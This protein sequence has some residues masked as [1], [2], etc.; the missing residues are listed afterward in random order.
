MGA[1]MLKITRIDI[2]LCIDRAKHPL[3]DRWNVRI[4]RQCDSKRILQLL[5]FCDTANPCWLVAKLFVSK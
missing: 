3:W 5:N 4:Y 1:A 2:K